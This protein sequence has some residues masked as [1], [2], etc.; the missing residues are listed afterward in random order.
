MTEPHASAVPDADAASPNALGVGSYEVVTR[1][2][3]SL[4]VPTTLGLRRHTVVD[5]VPVANAGTAPI[6]LP[7]LTGSANT[8]TA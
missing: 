8:E 2:T 6:A 3:T 5:A 1:A 4:A 7:A